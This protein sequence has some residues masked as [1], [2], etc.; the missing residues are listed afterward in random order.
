VA[1]E[2]KEAEVWKLE[3][4]QPANAEQAKPEPKRSEPGGATPKTGQTGGPAG[5]KP[6]VPSYGISQNIDQAATELYNSYRKFGGQESRSVTIYANIKADE[7]V[8]RRGAKTGRAIP[9]Q[10]LKFGFNPLPIPDRGD[11][12]AETGAGKDPPQAT[13]RRTGR[14]EIPED[15]RKTFKIPYSYQGSLYFEYMP[16]DYKGFVARTT[17][18]E[19]AEYPVARGV[20]IHQR[21]FK[22]GQDSY[23]RVGLEFSY[24]SSYGESF[25]RGAY[26][27]DA[28]WEKK[29][30]PP[31]AQPVSTSALGNELPATTLRLQTGQAVRV[32][33]GPR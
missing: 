7:D 14:F 9:E 16:K 27:M 18:G 11:K 28:C 30:A 15:E 12:D 8:L 21:D 31:G 20:E 23:R 29:P 17:T 10:T 3:S 6:N 19:G 26:V 2:N 24:G 13:I 33:S 1:V 25:A 4:G 5:E 22:I 32:G